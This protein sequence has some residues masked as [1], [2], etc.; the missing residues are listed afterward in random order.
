MK[1]LSLIPC[2]AL[3]GAGA[4]YADT[5]Q[6]DTT[7]GSVFNCVNSASLSG[8]GTSQINIGGIISL[9]YL[10]TIS[11]VGVDPILFPTTYANFGNLQFACIDETTTCGSQAM[12]LGLS[13][14]ININQGLPDL[15]SGSLPAGLIVGSIAG[16]S[17]NASIQWAPGSSLE[18]EGTNYK[19]T[20]AIVSPFVTLSPPASCTSGS[21]CGKTTIQGQITETVIP[22]PA[23]SLLCA[24]G[25]MAIGGLRLRRKA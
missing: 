19:V 1:L 7:A 23:I 6:Y 5:I 12:P 20:Y 8:C 16:A 21:S 3:L 13:L 15:L 24:G 4:V 14:T 11:S 9:T 2:L 17:S 18:L 22:E 10:P 25:L